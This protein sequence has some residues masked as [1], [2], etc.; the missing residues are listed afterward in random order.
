M[1]L[2]KKVE[3]VKQLIPS[4]HRIMSYFPY[5]VC[6][7]VSQNSFMLYL[8]VHILRFIQNYSTFLNRAAGSTQILHQSFKMPPHQLFI[9]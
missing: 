3:G 9:L 5:D 4:Y 6:F 7:N 1:I 2:T 8:L